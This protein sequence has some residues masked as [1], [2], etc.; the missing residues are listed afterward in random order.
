MSVHS[1]LLGLLCLD[2]EV[3]V[4]PAAASG[5]DRGTAKR[6]AEAGTAVRPRPCMGTPEDVTNFELFL[7]CELSTWSTH[8][9]GVMDG[10]GLA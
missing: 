5:L 10:S 2:G 4:F 1:N 6:L 3:A 8:T 9:P 7:T